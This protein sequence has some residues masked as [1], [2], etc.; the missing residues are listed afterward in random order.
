MIGLKLEEIRIEDVA[1]SCKFWEATR[2]A[3]AAAAAAERP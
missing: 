2:Q 3:V 1:Q